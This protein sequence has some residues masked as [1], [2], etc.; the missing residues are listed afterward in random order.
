MTVSVYSFLE[1]L[2]YYVIQLTFD[3]IQGCLGNSYGIGLATIIK[4][5]VK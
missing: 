5:L 3:S 2:C 4:N 1:K